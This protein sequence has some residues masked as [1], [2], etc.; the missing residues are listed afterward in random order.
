MGD[1]GVER[2]EGIFFEKRPAHPFCL[3]GL[4]TLRELKW[5][6]E[7]REQMTDFSAK[8]GRQGS[9]EWGEHFL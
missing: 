5:V 9:G 6:A 2:G 3:C 8:N 1:R 4:A 7:S